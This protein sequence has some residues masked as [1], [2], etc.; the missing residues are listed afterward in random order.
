MRRRQVA[1]RAGAL[2]M[3]Q[4][5]WASRQSLLCCAWLSGGG[6]M[7]TGLADAHFGW[8]AE[9]DPRFPASLFALASGVLAIALCAALSF[10]ML[11]RKNFVRWAHSDL[12][13]SDL[14]GR[15]IHEFERRALIVALTHYYVPFLMLFTGMIAVSPLWLPAFIVQFLVLPSFYW[16]Q[17]DYA[18]RRARGR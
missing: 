6:A 4:T 10:L 9:L 2:E 8:T 5:F 15:S 1:R 18:R 7:V 14:R 17:L 11:G 12:L 3:G 13:Y 16:S